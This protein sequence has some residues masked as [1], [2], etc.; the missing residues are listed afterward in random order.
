MYVDYKQTDGLFE[1]YLCDEHRYP[2]VVGPDKNGEDHCFYH[3]LVCTQDGPN[4]QCGGKTHVCNKDGHPLLPNEDKPFT[5]WY[6]CCS[7]CGFN[8]GRI[9]LQAKDSFHPA[10]YVVWDIM[11]ENGFEPLTDEQKGRIKD[12]VD[13]QWKM[14]EEERAEKKKAE[15]EKRKKT[16][17][18]E[19]ESANDGKLLRPA[20]RPKPE[21]ESRDRL[22]HE[23]LK[24]AYWEIIDARWHILQALSNINPLDIRVIDKKVILD[25]N[26]AVYRLET[27]LEKGSRG[28]MNH[29]GEE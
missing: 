24:D 29:Q 27:F 9:N 22:T 5:E 23:D 4:G 16:R 14:L 17:L 18:T 3:H 11:H 8:Y 1:L 19:E 7:H 10:Y 12:V 25:L 6:L 26:E 2:Y 28:R 20:R 21:G 13:K 15:W